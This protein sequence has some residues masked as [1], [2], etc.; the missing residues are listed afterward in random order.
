MK[1][2]INNYKGKYVMHCKTEKE[3]REFCDY[4]HSVGRKWGNGKSYSNFTNWYEFTCNSCYNFNDNSYYNRAYYENKGY[5]ILEWSDF[6]TEFTKA[7][8]KD[9]MVVENRNGDRLLV[10][11]DCFVGHTNCSHFN[12]IVPIFDVFHGILFLFL[13]F[14]GSF[15]LI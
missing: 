8:L 2:D 1:F 5:T 6:T 9:G 14:F 3:A 12:C 15:G 10:L 11:G 4:L 7:D 13:R